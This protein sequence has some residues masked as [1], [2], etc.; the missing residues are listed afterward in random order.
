V[1]F[2]GPKP[3]AGLECLALAR[4]K[5]LDVDAACPTVPEVYR[6][7]YK[8]AP[9][10]GAYYAQLLIHWHRLQAQSKESCL[11]QQLQHA[12]E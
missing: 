10:M 11:S 6:W 5:G 1:H 7:C 12:A 9:D 4:A 2:H 8:V 3:Q